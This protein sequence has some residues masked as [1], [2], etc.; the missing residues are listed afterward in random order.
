MQEK[1]K[2]FP[3]T[4]KVTSLQALVMKKSFYKQ[5]WFI[6][7]V[8]LIAFG[9]FFSQYLENPGPTEAQPVVT[10][11]QKGLEESSS[12]SSKEA[13]SPQEEPSRSLPTAEEAAFFN[14]ISQYQLPLGNHLGNMADLLS[15]YQPLDEDWIL[16][17]AYEISMIQNYCSN[18]IQ[19]TPPSERVKEAHDVYIEHGVRSLYKSTELLVSGLDDDNTDDI[20]EALVY[21][22]RYTNETLDYAAW[23]EETFE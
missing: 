20:N 9:I 4:T 7:V 10:A 14:E 17:I 22:E 1:E 2:A 23:L 18:L 12:S 13:I 11:P 8:L 5:P 3:L 16:K 6:V 19:M 21:L 15:S